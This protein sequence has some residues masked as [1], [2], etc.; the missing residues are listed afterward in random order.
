MASR[1]SFCDAEDLA[2]ARRGGPSRAHQAGLAGDAEQ[3]ALGRQRHRRRRARSRMRRARRSPSNSTCATPIFTRPLALGADVVMH[4]A[5]KYLN[6]HSDVIAGA[7]AFARD[8]ELSAR[9][10]KIRAEPRPDPRA[11]RGVP[12][13]PRPAHARSARARRGRQRRRSWRCGSPTMPRSPK[14]SIPACRIIPATRSPSGRCA[15]ASAACCRSACAAAR[16][17]RSRR[18]RG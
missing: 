3:S 7:L 4:S 13:D 2:D 14:C 9:V 16:R 17:R 1:S 12:A 6:G 10:R 11:V 5:T 18:R 15:A 8:D